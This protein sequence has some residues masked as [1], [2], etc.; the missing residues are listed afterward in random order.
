MV[1]A[2]SLFLA[3]SRDRVVQRWNH[4]RDKPSRN[5]LFFTMCYWHGRCLR[6]IFGGLFLYLYM[7]LTSLMIGEKYRLKL[8]MSLLSGMHFETAKVFAFI[9]RTLH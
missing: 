8:Y 9:T 3:E 7:L 5:T 2:I 6:G 1:L 4:Q